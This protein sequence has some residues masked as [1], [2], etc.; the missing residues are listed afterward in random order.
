MLKTLIFC[1]LYNIFDICIDYYSFFDII[2][3][4]VE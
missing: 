2:I 4:E 3:D 1:I